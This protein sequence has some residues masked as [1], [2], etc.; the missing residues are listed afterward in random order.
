MREDVGKRALSKIGPK[1][2][3]GETGDVASK[4]RLCIAQLVIHMH[5]VKQE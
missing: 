2:R 3:M 4:S 1:I 5:G